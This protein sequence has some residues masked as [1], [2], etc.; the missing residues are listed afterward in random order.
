MKPRVSNQKTAAALTLVEVMVVMVVIAVLLAMVL[1][2]LRPAVKKTKRIN[3][4]NLLKQVGLSYYIWA[5]DHDD[6]FPMSVSVA[7]GGSMEPAQA[8]DAASTFLVMS[9]ELSSPKIL[10]C[11]SDTNRVASFSFGQGLNNSN[12]SYFVG[13]DASKEKPQTI[14]SGDDNFAVGG[15]PVK[16]GLLE[17][18]T[19]APVV[20]TA[21]RHNLYGNI[22][23]TDGSVQSL[24]NSIFELI[25]TKP[26]LP[27]TASRFRNPCLSVSIRG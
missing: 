4:V 8:G 6:K 16:S 2:A 3:C 14:L 13:L 19:N 10:V 17:L 11:L 26:A 1:P 20:W 12:I 21:A 18:S 24:G 15:V 5:N 25:F 27:P 23:F 9:N 7:N 22:G